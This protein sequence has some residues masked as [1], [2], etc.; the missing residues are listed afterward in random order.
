M[1]LMGGAIAAFEHSSI[2]AVQVLGKWTT[3][4]LMIVF[5]FSYS[6]GLEYIPWLINSEIYPLFLIGS[7]SALSA[8][9]HWIAC[10]AIASCFQ[11]SRVVVLIEFGAFC[12]FLCYIF[13][14][15]LVAETNGNSIIKNVAL[16]LNKSQREVTQ[17]VQETQ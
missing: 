13:V 16:M 15:K 11:E 9:A 12:N 4:G 3:L 5:L 7:A 6:V 17:F 2:S 14:K 10:F 8:F 1:L